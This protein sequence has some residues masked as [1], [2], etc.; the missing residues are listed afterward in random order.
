MFDTALLIAV[1]VALTQLIKKSELMPVKYMPT[2]SLALGIVA[3]L[4]FVDGQ[5]NEQLITGIMIGLSAAGLFDQTKIV[6]KR[7]DK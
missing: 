3:G 6:T 5:L 4:F 1:I 7:G 2:L